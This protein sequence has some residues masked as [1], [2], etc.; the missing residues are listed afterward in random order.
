M[1]HDT[2]P[3]VLK[4]KGGKY[5]T[6]QKFKD[7]LKLCAV[8]RQNAPVVYIWTRVKN[9]KKQMAFS[10]QRTDGCYL[11]NVVGINLKLEMTA[12]GNTPAW[13]NLTESHWFER[14]D[15]KAGEHYGLQS[16]GQPDQ[17]LSIDTFTESIVCLSAAPEKC[18]HVTDERKA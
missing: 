8:D 1:V 6:V 2:E 13:S 5:V 18:V 10:F 16:V 12:S 7:G 9:E 15:L 4:I 11:L 14:I 3:S 17:Y